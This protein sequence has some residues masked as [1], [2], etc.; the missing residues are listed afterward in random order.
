[1]YI[2]ARPGSPGIIILPAV[3]L[4]GKVFGRLYFGA[5]FGAKRHSRS[6]HLG[7]RTKAR[8]GAVILV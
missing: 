7:E 4:C 2:I 8:P 6:V 1:M 5:Q 3:I